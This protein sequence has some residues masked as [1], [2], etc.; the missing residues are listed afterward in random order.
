LVKATGYRYKIADFPLNSVSE[1]SNEEAELKQE[2][3]IKS[4]ALNV[5][6][7]LD[8]ITDSKGSYEINDESKSPVK[9]DE[10][11]LEVNQESQQP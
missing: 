1:V 10:V 8:M 9:L 5:A 3:P 4:L 2:E 11:V 6:Q 7:A